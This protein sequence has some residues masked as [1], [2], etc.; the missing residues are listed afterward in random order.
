MASMVTLLLVVTIGFYAWQ[1]T[2]AQSQHLARALEEEA[3]VIAKNIADLSVNYVLT[4]D[5]A[6]MEALL[7]KTA[8]RRSVLAITLTNASGTVLSQVHRAV[9][10][11]LS[12][13]YAP[14]TMRLPEGGRPTVEFQKDRIVVWQ[15]MGQTA[16]FGW[17][18]LEYSL[19]VIE[20]LQQR[21]W[22]E[23]LR[24]AVP[25]VAISALLLIFFLSRHIKA[26]RNITE[27]ATRLKEQRG[28]TVQVVRSS[29]E[30]ER[31]MSALNDT[32]LRLH[33]QTNVILESEKRYRALFEDSKDGIIV[34]TPEDRVSDINPAGVELLGYGSKEEV[35]AV[36]VGT[37]LYQNARERE[38]VKQIVADRGFIKDHEV[39]LRKKDGETVTVLV[40]ATPVYDETGSIRAYRGIY[41]DVTAE[42]MLKDQLLHAQK[43]EAVGRLTGGIAHDFNNILSAIISYLYLLQKKMKK[44][45]P[46]LAY[47]DQTLTTVERAANLTRS[48]LAFSRKQANNPGVVDLNQIVRNVQQLMVQ[49][50]GEDV[51]LTSSLSTDDQMVMAD[52]GQMEQVLLNLATNARD[53]MPT[54]GRLTVTTRSAELG[55]EFTKSHGY[56][57]PGAY[58][59]LTMSDEGIGMDEKTL[60]NIFEPFF[61][62]K[63]VGK[64][65]G[66][67]LSIVYGIVKQ[68]NGY[69]TVTSKPG[70]GTSFDLYLPKAEEVVGGAVVTA[71]HEAVRGGTETI[72]VAE[73]DDDVRRTTLSV[74]SDEGYS[75][76]EAV[77]G[78]EAVRLFKKFFGKI[79]LILLDAVMPKKRGEEVYAEAIK[80]KPDVKVLFTSGYREQFSRKT[81]EGRNFISK[82]VRPEDLLKK[83][84]AVLDGE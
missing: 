59:R 11:A 1:T 49:V 32:S 19:H 75:I 58:V 25:V 29:V 68:H 36:D 33:E 76:V 78:E 22:R 62:T 17:V 50:L 44:G 67:G 9:G 8:E 56:G 48:L 21:I 18:E 77:D 30:I 80:I 5:F 34:D 12:V 43:M 16:V 79:D 71:K 74:L 53:A 64:G 82:P 39:K 26:I 84:R 37:E 31:L 27:F 54:G 10:A 42:R 46:L 3:T 52:S 66:L 20:E 73:D 6:S 45:D 72:L 7:V 2:R 83:I 60:K 51:E 4:D 61:T 14:T 57:K 55:E 41:R 28:E 81:D 69:I 40:T 65:T 23:S 35:M 70:A 24:T 38:N 15:P 47:V 13:N 63:G